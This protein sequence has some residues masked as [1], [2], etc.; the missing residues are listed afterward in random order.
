MPLPGGETV[1]V[2]WS[3][4]ERPNGVIT[5]YRILSY[6]VNPPGTPAVET[7]ITDTSVLN[8]TISGLQPYTTYDIRI[9]AS[10]VGGSSVGPAKNVTTEESGIFCFSVLC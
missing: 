8:A 5:E 1:I 7:V 4:P 9:Q 10:T 3:L 2:T 6:R